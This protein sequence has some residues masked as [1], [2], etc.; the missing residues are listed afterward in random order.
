MSATDWPPYGKYHIKT[1]KR[2]TTKK[3][4]QKFWELDENFW[5]NAEIFSGNA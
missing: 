3:G 5:G 4:H 1:L 2:S